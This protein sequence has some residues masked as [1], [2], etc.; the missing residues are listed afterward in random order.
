V[1]RIEHFRA[2]GACS[3]GEGRNNVA[4]VKQPVTGLSLLLRKA[5]P[6]WAQIEVCQ[7][8][9]GSRT[10]IDLCGFL[11]RTMGIELPPQ[12]KSLVF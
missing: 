10:K 8:S 11:E 9:K 12:T 3:L 1:C 5:L 7:V 2:I 4:E 6:F